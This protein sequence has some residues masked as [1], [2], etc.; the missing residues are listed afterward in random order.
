MLIESFTV[1]LPRILLML[2]LMIPLFSG[3]ASATVYKWNL[4]EEFLGSGTSIKNPQSDGVGH[5]GVWHFLRTMNHTGDVAKRKW[6]RDGKYTPLTGYGSNLGGGPHTGWIETL[7]EFSLFIV[8]NHKPHTYGGLEFQSGDLLLA[9]GTEHALVIGWRSP[10]TGTL[11]IAGSIEH[12]MKKGRFNWYLERGPAPN[13]TQG[14]EPVSLATGSCQFGTP[15][16]KQ[17]FSAANLN[18]KAGE[19]IYFVVD[20]FA[21]GT[22]T[23]HYFDISRLHLSLTLENNTPPPSFEKNVLPILA[24]NCFDCHNAETREGRL[25]LR[26]VSTMLA[27]GNNGP[28]VINGDPGKSL[29]LDMVTSGDMPPGEDER[30]SADEISVL[31][32]WIISG[33]SADEKIQQVTSSLFTEDERNHWAFRPL[34][35]PDWPDVKTTNQVVAPI[36]QFLWAKLNQNGLSFSPEADRA[37]LARRVYYDVI[38]LPPSPEQVE[39]FIRDTRPDAYERLVDDL[40][41]SPQYGVRWARHWLDIVGYTDTVSFDEDFSKPLG[42]IDDK[43]RYRDYVV[44]SLNADKP[45]DVFVTEQLAGDELV[46]W[47]DS[48]K[49]TPEILEKLVATGYLRIVEDISLEDPRQ[50]IIW[51]VVHETVEDMATGL[52]GLTLNCAKYHSHKF[53][54]IPQHD[55]YSLM[56]LFTPA[57][58]VKN[59]KN[60]KERLLPDVS[61]K[62][63]AAL[64][65]RNAEIAKQV[66]ELNQQIN[67]IRKKYELS[68]FEQKLDEGLLGLAGFVE[69]YEEKRKTMQFQI[70]MEAAP[71]N[72]GG[73]WSVDR[74]TLEYPA[75]QVSNLPEEEN[76]RQVK[77]LP[78][79]ALDDDF[80]ADGINES[81]WVTIVNDDAASIKQANGS[82]I[83]ENSASTRHRWNTQIV[84]SSQSFP[85]MH[86]GNGLRMTLHIKGNSNSHYIVGLL[87]KFE[88]YPGH[89]PPKPLVGFHQSALER[90]LLYPMKSDFT[91]P[92]DIGGQNSNYAIRI[93][94]SGK[95][96]A[97]WE[98]DL[99]DGKGWQTARTA[100]IGNPRSALSSD[101]KVA[102]DVPADKRNEVQKYLVDKLGPLVKVEPTEIDAVLSPEEKQAIEKYQQQ[103]V[104][105]SSQKKSHGWIHAMYDVGPAPPTHLFKRG[106]FDNPGHEVSAGFLRVLSS[107]FAETLLPDQEIEIGSMESKTTGRRA[108]LARW[109]TDEQS[110]ASGLLARVM[111]NRIWQRLFGEGIVTT[112]ENLGLSGAKPT[113][114]ELLEW[115][116]H[117]FRD[118]GW[119]LKRVVKQM[120]LSAAY[121]QS[122]FRDPSAPNGNSQAQKNDPDN[123]LLWRMRLRRLD[124][125]VLRDAM[126]TI[127]GKVDLTLGG[128][129]IPLEYHTGTGMVTVADQESEPTGKW[130]QSLYLLQ[131][132]IYNPTLLNVF[133]KPIVTGNVCERDS[134]ATVLQS[135]TLMNDS[136][137]MEHATYF[138][139]RVIRQAGDSRDQQIVLAFRLTYG[140]HPT[141][142]EL[143]LSRDYMEQQTKLFRETESSDIAAAQKALGSLCQ[144]LWGSNEFLYLQ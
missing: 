19:F 44:N 60:P 70:L 135:L 54:P 32:S 59:W 114:P 108:A 50:F 82:L 140:R 49:Y 102:L 112:S 105:A 139:N 86:E 68:L 104:D 123:M 71:L 138:A 6:L 110:P 119:K 61:T 113:H 83:F 101:L 62:E 66:A 65:Q 3:A 57:F 16:Q 52:L 42:M 7:P 81:S 121:R 133:D 137:V 45:Y 128:P 98:Y 14:F 2:M 74:V 37:T 94:L 30:L 93:T 8:K 43:W 115:L 26:T 11:S 134:S 129:P 80:N 40:L 132:R 34:V 53:E 144:T 55:Y 107:P 31:T 22:A 17:E 51:S 75:E 136:F 20:A 85:A 12:G 103:I 117:D 131:R 84:H 23:P 89:V 69:S 118:N 9:P 78:H 21:D 33:L 36:D 88:E 27:G 56:A 39:A 58:N 127:G 106:E 124:A 5:P 73:S 90:R 141:A 13:P 72:G 116:A 25:D 109:L 95:S 41:M 63:L 28:A 18:I 99:R 76:E 47:R 77:S 46:D 35:R 125:E 64:N 142:E 10:L 38:G 79:V 122:S 4:G 143:Q 87:P 130:R 120:L 67:S 15:T 100:K 1:K 48:E 111:V 96:G 29:L 97:L 24:A 126:L 92:V 91:V